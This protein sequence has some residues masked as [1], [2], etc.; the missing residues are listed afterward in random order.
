M[1]KF[2]GSRKAAATLLPLVSPSTCPLLTTAD[3]AS[4]M[5]VG[6]PNPGKAEAGE[7]D[8]DHANRE[9]VREGLIRGTKA[10]TV[11]SLVAVRAPESVAAAVTTLLQNVLA[12][13]GA[14]V[15]V[16]HNEHHRVAFAMDGKR[17][18]SVLG[19]TKGCANSSTLATLLLLSPQKEEAEKGLLEGLQA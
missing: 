15:A 3:E 16:P 12:A 11:P 1:K 19:I 2:G 9:A 7:A 18:D 5:T 8:L 14:M 6:A 13:G 17:T 10:V 4:P